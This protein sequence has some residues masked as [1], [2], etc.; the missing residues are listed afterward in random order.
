MNRTAIKS[1]YYVKYYRIDVV[2]GTIYVAGL[3][4][5]YTD[6]TMHIVLNYFTFIRTN[7]TKS[8]FC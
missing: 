4:A 6:Q 7:L 8:A 5:L 3:I 2:K 1:L